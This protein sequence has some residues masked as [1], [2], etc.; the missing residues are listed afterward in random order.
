MAVFHLVRQ[1]LP[2]LS[3]LDHVETGMPNLFWTSLSLIDPDRY[4]DCVN[5]FPVGRHHTIVFES[6]GKRMPVAP[7]SAGMSNLRRFIP[8]E[9][10]TSFQVRPR[11]V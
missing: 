7:E 10:D 11:N 5:L 1:Y 6:R 4:A 9:E 2:T 3:R 8:Y